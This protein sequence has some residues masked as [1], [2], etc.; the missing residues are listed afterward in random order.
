M[1]RR[2]TTYFSRPAVGLA[3]RN[4]S[5]F[6]LTPAPP[7]SEIQELAGK[8]SLH[9]ADE[10]IVLLVRYPTPA[11]YS[12]RPVGRAACL[13]GDEPIRIYVPLLMRPW[14]MQASHSTASCHLGTACTLRMLER[15]YWRIEMSIYTRWWLRHCL[16][17]QARKTPRLTVRWPII[18][19]PLPPGLGIA[20][21]VDYFGT[22][23]VTPRG[24]TCRPGGVSGYPRAWYR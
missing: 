20:V 24:N 17:C 5:A 21:S 4:L 10:D 1:L 3:H 7:F 22:L 18:S 19:T 9:T 16:K 13:L 14:L 2:H 11:H 23:P 15:F 6:P 8:G 12:L